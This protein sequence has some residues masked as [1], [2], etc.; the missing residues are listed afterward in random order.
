M[1]VCHVLCVSVG[2][3]AKMLSPLGR[4]QWLSRHTL[5]ACFMLCAYHTVYK[6][7]GRFDRSLIR[8]IAPVLMFALTLKV[9]WHMKA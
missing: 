5:L 8:A 1:L 2:I 3:I 7:I 4:L 9:S 6:G